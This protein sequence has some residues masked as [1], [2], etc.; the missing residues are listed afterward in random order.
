MKK[1]ILT[2]IA[3]ATIAIS[4]AQAQSL[5]NVYVQGNVGASKLNLDCSG[6]AKCDDKDV[7]VKAL[8]GYNL[9]NGF[10]AE[11]GYTNY[12]KVKAEGDINGDAFTLNLKGQ[13]FTLGAAYAYPLSQEF[14]L[15]GRAGL[16][17]NKTKAEA[18]LG[19]A[20]GSESET[21]TKPYFG[22]GV[23]YAIDKS[24]AV[25]ADVD[26]TKF[27]FGGESATASNLS[28]FVRYSF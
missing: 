14:S 2:A 18:T 28:A 20:S 24:I 21:K 22:L 17:V 15:I 11:V 13:A 10:S 9:G 6:A 25:G 23:A 5:Q 19:T 1:Q 26:F 7:G 8:V 4:A 27:E 16:S 12:G 3:F